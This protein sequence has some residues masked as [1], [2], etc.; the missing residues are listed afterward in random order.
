MVNRFRNRTVV[1][2]GASAGIGR[3]MARRL[4]EAGANVGLVA[5]RREALEELAGPNVAIFPGDVRD[6]DF[7][8][9]AVEGT[10]EAFG[11]IDCAIANAGIS[12]NAPFASAD[13]SVF[14]EM[15]EVNYFGS[16]HVARFA[17]PHLKKSRGSLVFI[18][19][20]VGKRGFPTRSGYSASKFAVQALFESL[21][22]EWAPEGIHVGIVAPGYTE[23]EIRVNALGSDG[24][25]RGEGGSTVGSVMS[26]DR[27][28]ESILKA[29]ADR[30]RETILTRGGK[31]MVLL[32]RFFP[33]L[34]DRVSAKVV[35]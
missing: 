13:L 30:R 6:A 12:M 15:M 1:V 2:T 34:A 9:R 31:A 28:A 4:I 26:A 8:S 16:L 5:R 35:G 17:H 18:S 7:C 14:R 27:A 32:N 19:S 33:A 22:V 21:R 29:A 23:T 20:V 25:P 24:K 11:G 10:A 3:A